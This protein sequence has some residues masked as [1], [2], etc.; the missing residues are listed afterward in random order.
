MQSVKWALNTF[1]ELASKQK[2]YLLKCLD[3]GLSHNYFWFNS[4]YKITLELQTK[5]LPWVLDMHQM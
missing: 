5:V 2:S 4:D 3:Y 1:S